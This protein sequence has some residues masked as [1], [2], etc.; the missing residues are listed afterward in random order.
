MSVQPDGVEEQ[1]KRILK[2]ESGLLAALE[3]LLGKEAGVLQSN[4][5]TARCSPSDRALLPLRNS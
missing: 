4:D 5:V 1:M 2:E 3:V